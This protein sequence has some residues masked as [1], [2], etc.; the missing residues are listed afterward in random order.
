MEAVLSARAS[1]GT[2]R[3]RCPTCR[4]PTT[5]AGNAWRPFC[6]VRCKLVDLGRW[7]DGGFRLPGPAVDPSATETGDDQERDDA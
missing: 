2:V 3:P 6:S 4:Q 5:W 7:L 1:H